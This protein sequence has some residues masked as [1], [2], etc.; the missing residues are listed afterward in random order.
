MSK[1]GD[2]GGWRHGRIYDDNNITARQSVVELPHLSTIPAQ[3]P[4][5]YT[6]MYIFTQ[7]LY[8]FLYFAEMFK[9]ICLPDS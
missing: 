3:D 6:Y 2:N 1:V 7:L 4:H 8:R 5:I 9:F